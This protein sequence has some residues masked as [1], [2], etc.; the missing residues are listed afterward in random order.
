MIRKAASKVLILA[1]V[2]L[3]VGRDDRQLLEEIRQG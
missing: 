3:V 1:A 2:T